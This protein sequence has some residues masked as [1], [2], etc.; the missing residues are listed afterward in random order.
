MRRVISSKPGF[1]R[2]GGFATVWALA[3]VAPLAI[4][5]Q[6]GS[7]EGR[8]V[9]LHTG[10]KPMLAVRV[11]ID[12]L[13]KVSLTDADGRFRFQHIPA[14]TYSL[15][16][17]Q[18]NSAAKKGDV[19]VT[20]GGS[21]QVEIS[22]DWPPAAVFSVTVSA[23]SRRP[24]RIVDA[25]AAVDVLSSKV[26][27]SEA[28]S[29]QLPRLLADQ[30]G[31]ELAQSG[32]YDFN[33]NSR[34]FNGATNRRVL[35]TI[36]GRDPSSPE[37]LGYQ[38]WAAIPFALDK[39]K[40][41]EFV[42][43]PGAALYGAG[44]YNGV[45]YLKT[46]SAWESLG[47]EARITGGDL[48]TGRS[49]VREAFHLG[50]RWAFEV[51]GGYQ[52]SGDFTQSRV[53]S[54]EYRPSLLQKEVVA[55]PLDTLKI[56]Y[57]SA[58]VDRSFGEADT[59]T[60]EFGNANISGNTSV[61][62]VGRFQ[63][64]TTNRPFGRVNFSMPG[65]NFLGFYTGVDTNYNLGLG[66]GAVS[67]DDG[68]NSGLEVQRNS[69]FHNGLGQLVLGASYGRDKVNSLNPQGV[70]TIFDQARASDRGAVFGQASYNFTPK[71]EG[72][73]SIRWDR[74]TLYSSQFS[75]RIAL[76][77]SPRPDQAFRVTFNDA[78]ESPSMSEFFLQ[79]PVAPPLDLSQLEQSLA[80]F[81][82]GTP[83]HFSSIP[84]LAVG[85]ED[86]KVERVRSLEAG[87]NLV[88]G[89]FSGSVSIYRSWLSDFT[90]NLL[91]ATG[92]SLGRLNPAYGPYVPPA[93]LSP[94][95]SAAV[96]AALQAALPASLFASLS[97]APD[98]SPE[99]V[100]LTFG[101]FGDADTDG[102]E[103]AL[104]YALNSQW[105]VQANYS[106]FGFKIKSSAPENPLVPNAP[107]HEANA[108]ISYV[109]KRFDAS[110]RY[111]WVNGF[112]WTSG[113]Y[114]GPV[115]SY[116]VVDANANYRINRRWGLGIDAANLL[117]NQHYEMFGGDILKRRILGYIEFHW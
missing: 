85:N 36:D 91:P 47:G 28:A 70:E 52:Q 32:L 66:S 93:A 101:N 13:G 116:S 23:V 34:G 38:Q 10:K 82:G 111:R 15:T 76:V 30:P 77:Y 95:A 59:L 89:S 24:E 71:L 110:A 103:A 78:F 56:A 1:F 96:L 86:L 84:L 61:T 99:F 65:W 22:V 117:N 12:S 5:A 79:T 62:P 43:G 2:W 92:T 106:Y 74:A 87:Y 41:V 94:Q 39:L 115:P 97:R 46:K 27:E 37:V 72:V 64:G 55:P 63:A 25:P 80:P 73:G 100:L 17:S 57:G 98:G 83:L 26:I 53:N 51:N 31:V 4:G 90:T 58:E 3:A 16:L 8:V 104:K 18:G 29:G 35:T 60:F 9:N 81:L 107:A 33:L 20:S 48:R 11:V 112:Q 44:A 6:W 88:R 109:N 40:K 21:T 54:V 67:Y 7:I 113:I 75:P 50:K 105:L 108:G 49:D 42:R 102:V 69:Y 19:R 45:L 114:S 68:Y 14:G